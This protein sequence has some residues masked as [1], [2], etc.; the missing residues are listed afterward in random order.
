MPGLPKE[1]IT[2]ATDSL[3]KTAF[4]DGKRKCAVWCSMPR[5]RENKLWWPTSKHT[6]SPPCPVNRWMDSLY[7]SWQ[8][9]RGFV[10]Y[11]II[12]VS[13]RQEENK[14]KESYV[15]S[16]LNNKWSVKT[17][18]SILVTYG[19]HSLFMREPCS[20]RSRP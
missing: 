8:G 18:G 19:S 7:D 2:T 16:H 15:K 20:K 14:P 17:K 13:S 11:L 5:P 3:M 1:F 10:V 6:Q 12:T 9:S 4:K